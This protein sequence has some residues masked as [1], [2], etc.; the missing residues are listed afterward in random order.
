[1]TDSTDARLTVALAEIERL[2][3][4]IAEL[5]ARAAIARGSLALLPAPDEPA[6]ITHDVPPN[7]PR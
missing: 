2:R 5:E 7:A 1:M 3:D 6:T 4:I